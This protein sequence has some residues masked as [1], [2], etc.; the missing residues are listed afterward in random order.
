MKYAIILFTLYFNDDDECEKR[1]KIIFKENEDEKKQIEDFICS[2]RNIYKF[3][4]SDF[5]YLLVDS[6]TVYQEVKNKI[7][8]STL[9][10]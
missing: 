1:I 9:K 5:L 3:L 7:D 2:V 8:I 6:V 4:N 10:I